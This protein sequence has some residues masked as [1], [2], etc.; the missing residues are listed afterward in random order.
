MRRTTYT[1]AYSHGFTLEALQAGSHG[2]AKHRFPG[3]NCA[4]RPVLLVSNFG[5]TILICVR[6]PDLSRPLQCTHEL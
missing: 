4:P 6:T 3:A 5:F 1:D 2:H